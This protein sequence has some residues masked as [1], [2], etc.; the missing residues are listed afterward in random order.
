MSADA[1]KGMDF[2]AL[3]C[4]DIRQEVGN[5]PSFMGVYTGALVVP[6]LPLTLPKLCVWL[7]LSAPQD[8]PL[9][10]LE[11][12]VAL[13]G[14]AELLRLPLPMPTEPPRTGEDIPPQPT[15]RQQLMLAL[16]LSPLHLPAQASALTVVLSAGCDEVGTASLPVVAQP[17][18]STRP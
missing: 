16:E 7:T 5:K 17:Q 14:G 6:Q 8:Q 18:A 15:A 12:A 1:P 13:E 9:Q 11:V 10:D 4:D 2:H 3:W